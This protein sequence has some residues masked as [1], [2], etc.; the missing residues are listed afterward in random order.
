MYCTRAY[1]FF[2]FPKRK[3]DF[4][5]CFNNKNSKIQKKKKSNKNINYSSFISVY[6]SC[7]HA[8]KPRKFIYIIYS[9]VI[10]KTV[11]VFISNCSYII[12]YNLFNR[13]KMSYIYIYNKGGV[14]IYYFFSIASETVFVSLRYNTYTTAV[15]I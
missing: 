3:H 14:F 9:C 4:C 2:S 5:C 13:L 7:V 11:R 6:A 1:I 10:Y 15:C 8:C 12:L